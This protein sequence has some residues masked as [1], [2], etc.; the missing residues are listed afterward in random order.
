MKYK[1]KDKDLQRFTGLYLR[2]FQIYIFD[3]LASV[4]ADENARKRA[5]TEVWGGG[6]GEN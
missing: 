4:K 1:P 5:S 3:G 6:T 2:Y